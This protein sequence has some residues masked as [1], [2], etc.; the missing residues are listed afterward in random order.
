M[1]LDLFLN[2]SKRIIYGKCRVNGI[3]N[4]DIASISLDTSYVNT[5][6]H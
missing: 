1:L 4:N 6:L 3:P 5:I 2:S